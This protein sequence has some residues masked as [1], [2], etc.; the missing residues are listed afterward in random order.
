MLTRTNRKLSA[1]SNRLNLGKRS[2][3]LVVG[4]VND[5]ETQKRIRP[6]DPQQRTSSMRIGIAEFSGFS[7]FSRYP[8]GRALPSS[9][10]VSTWPVWLAVERREVPIVAEAPPVV[11]EVVKHGHPCSTGGLRGRRPAARHGR[12]ASLPAAIISRGG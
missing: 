7:M 10:R 8:A 4:T 9:P 2:L 1:N 6:D 3:T 11:R 5:A 12:A